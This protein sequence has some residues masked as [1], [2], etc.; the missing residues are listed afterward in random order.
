MHADANDNDVSTREIQSRR[1]Q[2]NS[3]RTRRLR[4]TNGHRVRTPGT[5]FLNRVNSIPHGMH[6]GDLRGLE[7]PQ[8]VKPMLIHSPPATAA[9]AEEEGDG[10]K[11]MSSGLSLGKRLN[12]PPKAA[13]APGEKKKEEGGGL[14]ERF[15]KMVEKFSEK[16][17][18]GGQLQPPP[19]AAGA[20]A[21]LDAGAGG[22]R[23]GRGARAGDDDDDDGD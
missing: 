16:K 19:A 7:T 23:A 15:K 3:Y 10:A 14:V 13:A 21:G 22:G 8:L 17:G 4:T 12:A 18:K 11:A 1:P 20:G 2:R 5:R 6:T 9:A